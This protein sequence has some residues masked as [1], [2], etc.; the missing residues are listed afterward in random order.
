MYNRRAVLVLVIDMLAL[1][2]TLALIGTPRFQRASRQTR[3]FIEERVNE[4][5]DDWS[6]VDGSG[7]RRGATGVGARCVGQCRAGRGECG[8]TGACEGADR[9][10]RSGQPHAN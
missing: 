5:S 10:Y 8:R 3:Q 6:S 9:R 4:S 2:A 1:Y 7:F